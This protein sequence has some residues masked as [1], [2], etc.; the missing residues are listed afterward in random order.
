MRTIVTGVIVFI[1]W[2]ALSTWYYV[3]YIKGEPAETAEPTEAVADT[4]G[5]DRGSAS[6]PEEEVTI[7]SPGSFTVYHEFDR[8]EI[9][10]D[11]EFDRFIKELVNY[12][13]QVPASRLDVTG[14]TDY[15]GTENYNY[16]LGMRRAQS[17]SDY[18]EKMGVSGEIIRISSEGENSP[19]ATNETATGRAQNRRTEIHINE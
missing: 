7:E 1:L 19:V 12:V 16:G 4:S 6:G 10:P 13:D 8:S 18:L 9:I 17:T 15:I 2:S 5:A 14:H 11:P 3:N